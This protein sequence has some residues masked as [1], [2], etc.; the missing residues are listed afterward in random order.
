VH[1][2]TLALYA[3]LDELRAAHPRLEIE[4]CASGGGRVDLGVL[5][6]TDRVWPS[7]TIDALERQQI[8]RWTT[9]LVPPELMGAHVGSPVSHTTGRTHGLGFRAATALLGHFGIEWDLTRA[10]AEER[11][12]L[13]QWVA[14]HRRLR[15]LV[16]DGVVVRGDHPDPALLVSGAVAQ[17]GAEAVFVIASVATSTAQTPLPVVLPGLRTDVRYTVER[18]EPGAE[19]APTLTLPGSVLT[20]VGIRPPVLRPESAT[21]LH[22]RAG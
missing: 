15:H 19:G 17:D 8:Q 7:D 18:V 20:H 11:S 13:A 5:E 1:G 4:S 2:Q 14:L 16:A 3:L 10:S 6:R 21:V 9:L 12:E 22:C